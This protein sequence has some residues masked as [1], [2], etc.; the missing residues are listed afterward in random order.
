MIQPRFENPWWQSGIILFSKLSSWIVAPVLIALFVGKWL[1]RK[2][3]TEPWL[4]LACV[5]IA[6]FISMFGIIRDTLEALK[7]MDKETQ[8]KK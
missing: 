2:F 8:K 1:D 6:F 4:F 5:G 3:S 7:K